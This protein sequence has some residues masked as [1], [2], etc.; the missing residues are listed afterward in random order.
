MQTFKGTN[1]DK[2]FK[3]FM[4][5]IIM[6]VNKVNEERSKMDGM[7]N[8]LDP[9]KTEKIDTRSGTGIGAPGAPIRDYELAMGRLNTLIQNYNGPSL[10]SE[11]VV[12]TKDTKGRPLISRHYIRAL[13]VELVHP[14]V[15]DQ[16]ETWELVH[17]PDE[18]KKDHLKMNNV[19]SRT[20]H[21][22]TAKKGTEEWRITGVRVRG[23][24][25]ISPNDGNREPTYSSK[26]SSSRVQ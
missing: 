25:S 10:N 6:L 24:I 3:K 14:E 12:Q 7:I 1:L 26:S 4:S 16:G 22:L 21:A 5:E 15:G 9:Q 13:E 2:A 8:M 19:G 18:E 11:L 20:K 17:I 23:L